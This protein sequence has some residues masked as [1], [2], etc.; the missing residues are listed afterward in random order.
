MLSSLGYIAIAVKLFQQFVPMHL[1][2]VV[3][4]MCLCDDGEC[5]CFFFFSFF[6]LFIFV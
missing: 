1:A 4:F 2:C 5:V 3:T 6:V